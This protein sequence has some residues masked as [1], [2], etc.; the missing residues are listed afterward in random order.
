VDELTSLS[1]DALLERTRE[2]PE[3]FG[4]FYERHVRAVIAFLKARG[5]DTEASLDLGA[6]VFAA[7]LAERD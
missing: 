5:L 6:E 1:D 3:A 2:D 7:A 4:V